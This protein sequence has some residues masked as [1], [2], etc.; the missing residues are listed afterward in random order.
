MR[1]YKDNELYHYGVLGMK[2]G[3]RKDSYRSTSIR[4]AIARRQNEKVDKGFKKWKKGSDNRADAISKGKAANVKKM[5]MEANPKNKNL[6]KEYKAAK[7]E[8]KKALRKNTTYRKGQV[9]NE[10]GKDLSRKYLTKAKRTKKALNNDPENKALRKEY[11]RSM[12]RHDI[13]RA[14]A[15]RAPAVAARRSRKI[16]SMKR[17]TT[18]TVKAAAGA[19]VISAGAYYANK[20]GW[21]INVAQVANR[22]KVAKKILAFL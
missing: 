19:A 20:K 17:A 6:R 9:R 5:E 2:W 1:T 21:N 8:Y 16:A 14:R 18:M 13:E 11:T 22:V 4:S 7:K 3:H 10:V 15:R 12:N